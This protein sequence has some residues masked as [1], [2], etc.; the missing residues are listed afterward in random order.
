MRKQIRG[1]QDRLTPKSPLCLWSCF[2]LCAAL[3]AMAWAG[4][5]FL[6]ELQSIRGALRTVLTVRF[7]LTALFFFALTTLFAFLTR[8]LLAGGLIAYVPFL[9]FGLINHFKRAITGAPF[10]LTDLALTGNVGNIIALNAKSLIPS[11]AVI[12]TVL[13]FLLWTLVLLFFSRPLKLPSWK[14]SLAAAAAPLV[15]LVSVFWIWADPLVFSPLGVKLELGNLFQ[16]AVNSRTGLPLGLL[17][18]AKY[19]SKPVEASSSDY[20]T[21]LADEAAAELPPVEPAEGV[22]PNVILIL[23]ESFFDVTTLP[24]VTYAQDPIPEFHALQSESVSGSFHSRTLGY[25]TCDIELEILTGINTHLMSNENLYSMSS[26]MLSSVPTVPGLMRDAGYRTVMMH[27]FNDSIYHRAPLMEAV[28]FE[29]RY[30]S[31]DFAAVDPEAAAAPDYYG[32]LNEHISGTYYSD[33]YMADLI[34]D[35]YENNPKDKP[36][37]TYAISME[38]HTPYENKYSPEDV[39]VSFTSPLTGEAQSALTMYSQAASNASA[40]LGK[41]TAYFSGQE[42]PTVILFFG[43]HRPGLGLQN[44]PTESVY[45][46]LYAAAGGWEGGHGLQEVVDLRTTSYLIWANDPSLLPD[47]PG[48]K[49][50]N[51]SNYFGL[52]ILDAAKVGKP[53]YWRLLDQLSQTRLMDAAEY[54]LGRD[55]A[56][57]FTLPEEGTDRQRLNRFSQFLFDALYHGRRVTDRLWEK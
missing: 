33:D 2:L 1:A 56:A 17:R 23:S 44:P 19:L 31:G 49:R 29:E 35:L 42:T 13:G 43:D 12:L 53:L 54:S 6:L 25:G 48:T 9:I 37:F 27:M 30:F 8:S 15:L 11:R 51:S 36:L 38:G 7:W 10:L 28:G 50:D 41:L 3:T 21:Q 18:S 34:I 47:A 26:D 57:S 22:H 32:F 14:V 16:T 40:S 39:T 24:G 45:S 46:G 5:T 20:L 4:L 55:G 52:S